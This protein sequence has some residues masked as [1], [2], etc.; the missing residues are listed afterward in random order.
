ML[1][2]YRRSVLLSEARSWL[3]TPWHHQAAVKGA[4][5]DCIGFVR[6]V[7]EPF[8]G[9][10][11]HRMDYAATWPLYRAEQL[12]YAEF[13]ARAKEIRPERAKPG[14]VLLF[15]VGKGPAHH[16]GYLAENDRLLHCYR[17]AGQVV[18]QDLTDFWRSKIRHAFRL[19]GIRDG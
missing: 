3:G 10:V 16:C 14:D 2:R 1:S 15:G 9:K 7:A 4:G 13:K 11:D 17:E 12:L 19:P 18:E 8:I 6:G 5:C